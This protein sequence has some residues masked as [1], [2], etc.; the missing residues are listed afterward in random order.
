MPVAWRGT[1]RRG[2]RAFVLLYKV[3][4]YL[5]TPAALRPRVGVRA[6]RNRAVA[7]RRKVWAK[8]LGPSPGPRGLIRP[9]CCSAPG[10]VGVWAGREVAE[11]SGVCDGR[12]KRGPRRCS[13]PRCVRSTQ[14]FC[15]GM[16]LLLCLSLSEAY[17]LGPVCVACSFAWTPGTY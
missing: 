7:V 17:V 2:R 5:R 8:Y 3:L 12:H 9:V 16:W 13:S 11:L 15:R 1:F 4:R 6:D 10:V 14:P